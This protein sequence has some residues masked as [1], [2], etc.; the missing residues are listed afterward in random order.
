MLLDQWLQRASVRNVPDKKCA[1]TVAMTT[2]VE[3]DPAV[4]QSG[5]E[6]ESDIKTGVE[7]LQGRQWCCLK[8]QLLLPVIYYVFLNL[9]F[10]CFFSWRG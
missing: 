6:E 4:L 5:C 9:R 8:T 2:L 7:K 1:W 10:E 3:E